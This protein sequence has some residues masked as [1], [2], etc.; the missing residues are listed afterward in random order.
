MG[1]DGRAERERDG[2]L[3][4]IDISPHSRVRV[5]ALCKILI[6][7]YVYTV[8]RPRL[9]IMSVRGGILSWRDANRA[10]A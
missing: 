2:G 6:R 5:I 10:S 7:R 4:R 9:G 3:I 1:E 8:S